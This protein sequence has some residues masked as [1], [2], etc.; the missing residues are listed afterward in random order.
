[1]NSNNNQKP[2][3][4]IMMASYN[5]EEY[6]EEQIDSILGQT[7]TDWQLY[8]RDDGSKDRTLEILRKYALGDARFHICTNGTDVHG[9]FPNFFAL[10]NYCK[11]EPSFDYYMFSDQDDYW[12]PDKIQK[13][14]D[15][16]QQEK[17]KKPILCYADMALMDGEGRIYEQSLDKQWKISEKGR[18][19]YFFSHKVSGCN[20]IMNYSLFQILPK[21][22]PG[23]VHVDILAH[24]AFCASVAAVFG[25]VVFLPE[26]LMKYRRHGEN[27]TSAVKFNITLPRIINRIFNLRR[28]AAAHAVVYNQSLIVIYMVQSI[29]MTDKQKQMTEGIRQTILKGGLPAVRFLKRNHVMFGHFVENASRYLIIG[30]GIYKNYLYQDV[31]DMVSNKN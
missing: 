15:R 31:L 17:T 2:T 23:G 18:V 4:C 9:A 22:D 28:L 8:I 21:V 11:E 12:Y 25:K 5:G 19:S 16:M 6:I 24:D 3:V 20:L 7:Y 13:M 1:M 27:V 30:T 29:E 10:I 26:S 14:V